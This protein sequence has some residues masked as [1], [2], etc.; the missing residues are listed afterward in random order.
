MPMIFTY[1]LLQENPGTE[2]GTGYFVKELI[3]RFSYF[4]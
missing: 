1:T 2:N 4:P 3:L